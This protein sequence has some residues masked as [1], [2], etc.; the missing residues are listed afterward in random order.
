MVF[1]GMGLIGV[2]TAQS[3]EVFA[4]ADKFSDALLSYQLIN[5]HECFAY[6]DERSGRVDSGVLDWDKLTEGRLTICSRFG[7]QMNEWP[8]QVVVSTN[9]AEPEIL[10]L[11][12]S[13]WAGEP[14][15][16]YHHKVF[17]KQGMKPADIYINMG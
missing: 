8:L 12:T 3:A 15:V 6:Q 11:E 1:V 7:T 5:S 10:T 9:M 13:S 4:E 14:R 17:I 16:I 2:G